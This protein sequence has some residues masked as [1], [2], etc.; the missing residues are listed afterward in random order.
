MKQLNDS[1]S[2]FVFCSTINPTSVPWMRQSLLKIVICEPQRLIREVF[3]HLLAR[4]PD[5]TVMA[6]A[7]DLGAALDAIRAV[8][9]PARDDMNVGST[10]N[11]TSGRHCAWDSMIGRLL[12]MNEPRCSTRVF[13]EGRR[14][15]Y[16]GQR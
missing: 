5:T 4:Y 12:S 11:T 9:H 1:S 14:G 16:S 10:A 3:A 13:P 15:T 7:A 8:I 6:E 2:D